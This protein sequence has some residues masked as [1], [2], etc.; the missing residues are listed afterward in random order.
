LFE[1]QQKLFV[2][3]GFGCNF[4]GVFETARG[5]HFSN[6]PYNKVKDKETCS[7]TNSIDL[8]PLAVDDVSPKKTPRNLRRL[9][10]DVLFGVVAPILTLIFDPVVFRGG[11]E[12]GSP[13]LARWRVFAYIAIPLGVAVMA[14]WLW[15]RF[16]LKAW[17]GVIAGALFTGA[18]FSLLVG[19]AILPAT[20]IGLLL[21]IGVLGFIPFLTAFVFFRNGLQAFNQA[22]KHL[23]LSGIV[24]SFMLGVVLSLTIPVAVHLEA[25]AYVSEG[26]RQVLVDDQQTVNAGIQRLK[27]AFW[28]DIDCYSSLE[29][30]YETRS[31][32]AQGDL[33]ANAYREIT[34]RDIEWQHYSD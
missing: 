34:G 16:R 2:N 25:E 9:I 30:S 8:Q 15:L 20:L 3:I 26:L 24:A 11:D 21:G 7:M 33:L 22:G 17:S 6:S 27:S 28:C 18:M 14:V 5:R 12:L 10:T 23:N 32:S 31:G 29:L 19:I 4:D 13:I 1:P